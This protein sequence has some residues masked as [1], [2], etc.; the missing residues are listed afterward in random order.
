MEWYLLNHWDQ[1]F[2]DGFSVSQPLVTMFFNG[3]Q[4]LVQRCDGNDTS[5]R[6]IWHAFR[7]LHY[8]IY[9]YIDIDDD[10]SDVDAAG[11]DVDGEQ[12]RRRYFAGFPKICNEK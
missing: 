8:Y 10:V 1:W 7:L 9:Q 2:F 3:C 5:F 11:V 6:S 12:K 4:P